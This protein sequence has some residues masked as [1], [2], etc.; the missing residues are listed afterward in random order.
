MQTLAEKAK[1]APESPGVYIFRNASGMPIY[2]GKAKNIRNRVQSYFAREM[3]DRTQQMV[4]T[5]HTLEFIITDNEAE[6][7]LLES[8][9]IKQHYPKYNIELKDNEKFTYIL[10]TDEEYPRIKDRYAKHLS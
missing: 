3:L 8:N 5:A 1:S 10:I 7:L 6:A 2:I 9:L 4:S